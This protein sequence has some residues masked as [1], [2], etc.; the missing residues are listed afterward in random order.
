MWLIE[1][2]ALSVATDRGYEITPLIETSE[3]AGVIQGM[4]LS[5]MQPGDIGKQFKTEGGKRTVAVMLHGTFKTA[6]PTGAPKDPEPAAESDGSAESDESTEDESAEAAEPASDT[7]LLQVSTN[8]STLVVVAD[9]DWLLDYSSVQRIE[10]LNAY[11]P[12]NDNLAFATNL[13][14]F[15]AGSEDL[16]AIRGKGRSQRPFDVIDRM[17]AAA[18]EKYQVAMTQVEGRLADIQAELNK[19]VQEQNSAQQLVATPEMREAIDKYRAEEAAAR[20]ERRVVRRQLRE[21]IESLQN[22]L[23]IINVALMP[24]GIIV[25]GIYYVVSRHSRRKAA[26]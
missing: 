25:F 14:D 13:V 6:F 5:F 12:R 3:R 9:T 23:T 10:Q 19:L 17:E 2:G 8:P 22:R 15:L 26:A 24:L 7:P 4:M 16:I 1:P 18:Q 21:G 11:M 20:A